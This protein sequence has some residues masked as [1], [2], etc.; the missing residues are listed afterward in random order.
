MQKSDLENL[1][2]SYNGQ[3][4]Y[5]PL[6]AQASYR[7]EWVRRLFN[8]QS[9]GIAQL[10]TFLC[11]PAMRQLNPDDEIEGENLLGLLKLIHKRELRIFG[12]SCSYENDP[13]Y[14]TNRVY[15]HLY[16]ILLFD[17]DIQTEIKLP[18]TQVLNA[19]IFK[20]IRHRVITE[21]E[22]R[23]HKIFN[24]YKHPQKANSGYVDLGL[25]LL[26]AK[27]IKHGFKE[28]PLNPNEKLTS[29]LRVI[30]CNYGSVE[31]KFIFLNQALYAANLV[32]VKIQ[33]QSINSGLRWLKLAS[34]NG[35]KNASL[36][37][38]AFYAR[39][40]DYRLINKKTD[41]QQT[42]SY[43]SLARDQ[44]SLLAAKTLSQKDYF[45]N[46]QFRADDEPCQIKC[47]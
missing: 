44:G 10:Q 31:V 34:S 29:H 5:E 12:T 35:D 18:T 38:A 13:N 41:L 2:E 39:R 26:F 43:L 20:H 33:Y 7:K 6:I 1:M 14:S 30:E 36:Q 15:E 47:F 22:K 37:L 27:E 19:V 4:N 42:L 23:A 25:S 46:V 40:G 17:A 3:V 45:G 9:Q 24:R 16:Q 11:S 8:I 21:L 28:Q 32:N